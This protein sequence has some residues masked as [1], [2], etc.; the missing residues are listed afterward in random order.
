M[1]GHES[2]AYYFHRREHDRNQRNAIHAKNI[3]RI[4]VK[5]QTV[6]PS[7]CAQMVIAVCQLLQTVYPCHGANVRNAI[8]FVKNKTDKAQ[9]PHCVALRRAFNRLIF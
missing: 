1:V 9:K 4:I 8:R 7:V 3:C 6:F 2:K 5:Q